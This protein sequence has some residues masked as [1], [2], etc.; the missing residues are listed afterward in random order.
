MHSLIVIFDL[1]LPLRPCLV[2]FYHLIVILDLALPQVSVCDYSLMQTSCRLM[3]S[4]THGMAR[5]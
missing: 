2:S 3:H 5:S 4:R 1:A